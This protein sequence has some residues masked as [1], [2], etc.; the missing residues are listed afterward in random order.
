MDRTTFGDLFNRIME[1]MERLAAQ[2]PDPSKERRHVDKARAELL[3]VAEWMGFKLI[4]A[5]QLAAQRKG[6][7]PALKSVK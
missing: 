3:A 4:T 7:K 1:D 5:E 2:M 6:K